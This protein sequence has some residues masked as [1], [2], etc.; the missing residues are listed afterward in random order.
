[1][2][3]TGAKGLTQFRRVDFCQANA[4]LAL[5]HQHGQRVAVV[6]G[7]YPRKR[8][9]VGMRWDGKKKRE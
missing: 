5:R 3:R 6:D 9:G 1:L 2:F 7:H 8:S 4:D